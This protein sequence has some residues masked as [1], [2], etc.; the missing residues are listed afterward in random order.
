MDGLAVLTSRATGSA[1]SSGATRPAATCG[2]GRWTARRST[3][4]TYV[5]TVADTNWEIRGQGDMNGDGKADLLWRNKV[6]RA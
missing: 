2:C 5:R 3:A 4:E 6:D 1:T